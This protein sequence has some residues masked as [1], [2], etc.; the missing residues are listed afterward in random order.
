MD[1]PGKALRGWIGALAPHEWI[2]YRASNVTFCTQG[3][4][5]TVET[6]WSL[7]HL[8]RPCRACV[9]AMPYFFWWK[10]RCLSTPPPTLQYTSVTYALKFAWSVHAAILAFG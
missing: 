5:G 3:L 1:P 4:R 2:L 10:S 9:D 7:D 8:S 6:R